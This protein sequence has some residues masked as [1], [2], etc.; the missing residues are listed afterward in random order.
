M[1]G[2]NR[3]YRLRTA[4]GDDA[5]KVLNVPIVQTFDTLEVL[6]VKIDQSGAY[7]LSQSGLGVVVGRVLANGGV[8]IQNAKVSIFIEADETDSMS[9]SSLYSYSSVYETNEDG[10]RYNL[11]PDSLDQSCYQNVGTFP[12]KR[13]VLDN[14]NVLETFDKYYKYTTV[15]NASGDYMIYGVPTGNQTLH[16]DIDLSD[17]GLLSQRPRDMVYKGYNINQFESPNKFKQ[18]TNLNS[19]SQI[20]SQ[21]IGVYVYPFWG[22]TTDSDGNVG[23][24]RCDVQID[25]KFEPTCVFIGSI[26][27][28]TGS[29]AI[30]KNCAGTDNVGKMSDLVAGEGSIEMIRKTVDNKVEEMQ[31]KGNRVIDG[32]GVWCYQIPMNLDYVMTD[33]FGNLVPTDNPDKGLPTRARVRFRISLDDP[34]S[35]NAAWK[36]CKFLVPNKPRVEED[37]FPEFC[38]TH[39]VDYEFGSNTL[40]ESYCDLFWNKVYT[41]K[42]YIPRVQKSSR[43]TNRKHTGIKLVNHYGDNN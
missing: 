24:T 4:V 10:I 30:G 7:K 15:T 11:L 3:V 37:R 38:K 22:D 14:D 12:N 43:S 17:I 42:N 27:S 28:D 36:R 19:L 5:P 39:E 16:V 41:V 35:D 33:E 25:Y 9:I 34:P 23:I 26:I 20:K 21:D 6:S 32:N 13:L 29:N 2:S 1:E 40:D 18:D 8:G 31:I